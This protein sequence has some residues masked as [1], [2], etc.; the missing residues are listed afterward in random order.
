MPKLIKSGTCVKFIVY[1]SPFYD[2]GLGDS[3]HGWGPAAGM[4]R[5]DPGLQHVKWVL[6]HA[7][8]LS[9]IAG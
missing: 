8:A 5:A 3:G 4:L 9:I 1:T 2:Q 6:P 7:Y